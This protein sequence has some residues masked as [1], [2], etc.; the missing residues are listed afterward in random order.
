MF[1]VV[2]VRMCVYVCVSERKRQGECV[3]YGKAYRD[4]LGMKQW[5]RARRCGHWWV[6]VCLRRVPLCERERERKRER[7]CVFVC[8]CLCVHAEVVV[9]GFEYVFVVCE[10]VCECVRECVFVSVSVSVSVCVHAEV[11]VGGF[12]YVFGVC[13]C[14]SVRLCVCLCVC[15]FV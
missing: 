10:C 12:E 13:P 6:R 7:V 11:V 15:V 9:G 14:S 4:Q 3:C 5:G 8:V 2:H 1:A